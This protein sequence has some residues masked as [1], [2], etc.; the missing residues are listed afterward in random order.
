MLA[1]L[2]Y[3]LRR[4]EKVWCP[5]FDAVVLEITTHRNRTTVPDKVPLNNAR[6][7]RRYSV[8]Y[9]LVRSCEPEHLA[10]GKMVV[11]MQFKQQLERLQMEP[12]VQ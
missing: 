12:T 6:D 3:V 8:H 5:G 2:E 9:T 11:A 7:A 4:L 1:G 10:C